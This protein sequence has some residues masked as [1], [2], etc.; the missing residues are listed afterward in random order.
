MTTGHNAKVRN[1]K[2]RLIRDRWYA[3]CSCGWNVAQ[4]IKDG[5]AQFV[6]GCYIG[7]ST[8]REARNLITVHLAKVKPKPRRMQANNGRHVIEYHRKEHDENAACSQWPACIPVEEKPVSKLH[9]TVP[10]PAFGTH[11]VIDGVVQEARN[12]R[13]AGYSAEPGFESWIVDVPTPKPTFF[14]A[15]KTYRRHC[16][17]SIWAQ[18]ND[19]IETL[20]V[21]VIEKDGSGKPVAFGRL[22]VADVDR[23]IVQ[24]PYDYGKTNALRQGQWEEVT[25]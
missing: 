17:W 9:P 7:R 2:V 19:V 15:G 4:A 20:K 5:D 16:D 13:R 6:D 18:K 21:T 8:E 22:T 24:H 12:R 10:V 1:A 14:E 23:W 25:S 3:E 11:L